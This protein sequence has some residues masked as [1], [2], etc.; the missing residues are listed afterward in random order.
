MREMR[1]D[2]EQGALDVVSRN[3]FDV[4]SDEEGDAFVEVGLS[5]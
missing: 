1:F 5:F 3:A 2:V 4:C